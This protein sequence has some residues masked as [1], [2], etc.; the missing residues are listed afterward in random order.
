MTLTEQKYEISQILA[1]CDHKGWL[2]EMAVVAMLAWFHKNRIEP[3]ISIVDWLTT[4]E[5]AFPLK[6]QLH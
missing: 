6:A 5:G 1:E 4:G 3:P 2:L